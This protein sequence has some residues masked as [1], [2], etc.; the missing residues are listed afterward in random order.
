MSA[1]LDNPLRSEV[2]ALLDRYRRQRAERLVRVG[3]CGVCKFFEPP[4]A[5]TADGRIGNP[6]G[7]CPFKNAAREADDVP[8]ET[9]FERAP[10]P[11]DEA[12][13]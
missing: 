5:M 1:Y 13:E 8:C 7:Y 4:D 2:D 12:A 6:F 10:A 11:A 9:W 3:C